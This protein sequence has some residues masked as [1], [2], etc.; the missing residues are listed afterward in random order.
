MLLC[1]HTEQA[2]RVVIPQVG[3]GGIRYVL[4]IRQRLDLICGYTGFRQPFMIK[5]DIPVAVVH[6]LPQ[7]FQLQR[8]HLSAVHALHFRIPYLTGHA[9]LLFAPV[10]MLRRNP[11]NFLFYLARAKM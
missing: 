2:E 8:L 11:Y 9:Y 5:F 4:D 10:R 7:A 6:K 3:L 1:R